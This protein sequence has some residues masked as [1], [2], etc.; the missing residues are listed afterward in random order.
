MPRALLCCTDASVIGTPFYLMERLHGRIFHDARLPEVA[1]AGRRAYYLEH[2]RGLAAL[3]KAD[4]EAT[5]PEIAGLRA[6]I[7]VLADAVTARAAE[8]A[9][10]R[11]MTVLLAGTNKPR[12][13]PARA[14][15]GIT[16]CTVTGAKTDAPMTAQV[17][18]APAKPYNRMPLIMLGSR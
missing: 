7:D 14:S 16:V 6:G 3:H 13:S 15:C 9:A 2:A 4:L 10:L 1:A 17:S 8:S 11:M 5:S 12:P 18:S